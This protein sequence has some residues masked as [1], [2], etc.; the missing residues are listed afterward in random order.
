V[1]TVVV[2]VVVAAADVAGAVEGCA[3]AG[4]GIINLPTPLTLEKV[5]KAIRAEGGGDVAS[6]VIPVAHPPLEGEGRLR[7]SAAKEEPGWGDPSTRAAFE[8]RDRHPTPIAH[9]IR[10]RPSPSR[11]G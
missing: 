10:D 4:L 3:T 5:W 2:A 1:A 8:R 9:F 7:L 11:G 6:I